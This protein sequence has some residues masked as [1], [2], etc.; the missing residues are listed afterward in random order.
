MTINPFRDLCI[1]GSGGVYLDCCLKD[2]LPKAGDLMTGTRVDGC[3]AS[4]LND[5]SGKLT[6][7]HYISEGVLKQF[8]KTVTVGG[9]P[10]IPEGQSKQL[11][12]GALK[13]KI[14]CSRHNSML[15]SIDDVGIR[16]FRA[17]TPGGG[18]IVR[19]PDDPPEF[20]VFRGEMIELWILKMACGALASG[21][22]ADRDTGLLI[23]EPIPVAW[24]QILLGL[25]PMPPGWGL[26]L[27]T[28]P[29]A[30][31]TPNS[32]FQFWFMCAGG[33]LNGVV[34]IAHNLGFALVMNDPPVNAVGTLFERA[35]YRPGQVTLRNGDR[36]RA[37]RFVW[38]RPN[39][40]ERHITIE[41]SPIVAFT[42]LSQESN[43]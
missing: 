39:R 38:E 9:L 37:V 10:W 14:L 25:A 16:F 2:G 33:S 18:H 21:N 11:P 28:D 6:G 41:T 1:C 27:R 4:I 42:E 35:T 17:F 34:L 31:Y 19:S 13:A 43:P 36:A 26:Y 22:A 5:C 29:G 23:Q 30:H 7:E 12:S 3:Y 20:R 32:V 8:G 40:D 24:I 15:S